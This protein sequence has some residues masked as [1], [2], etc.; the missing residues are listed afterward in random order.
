MPITDEKTVLSGHN[1]NHIILQ[2]AKKNL[3]SNFASNEEWQI[4]LRHSYH[5]IIQYLYNG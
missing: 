1:S 3:D 5:S 4:I 2:L